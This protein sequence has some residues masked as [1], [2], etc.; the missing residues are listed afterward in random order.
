MLTTFTVQNF[1][2]LRDVTLQLTPLHAIVG[3]NDSGKSTLLA[4][5]EFLQE[6]DKSSGLSWDPRLSETASAFLQATD[7]G[8]VTARVRTSGR[9]QGWSEAWRSGGGPSALVVR[10][11]ADALRKPAN[12]IPE[13]KKIQF[14]LGRGLGLPGVYD[15]ILSRGDDAFHQIS[16]RLSKLFQS[17]KRLRLRAVSA[18]HKQIEI[19]LKN[20]QKISA[21][22]M[23]E[24]MLYYLAFE[25]LRHIEGV[26]LLLIE[27][28]ENGLHPARIAEV[29][30]MLRELTEQGTQ[31][32]LTTHS[33]LVLNE[34]K[35]EEVSVL[36]REEDGSRA[37]RL[38]DTPNFKARSEVFSLGELWLN[39]CNGIDEAPLLKGQEQADGSGASLL[40]A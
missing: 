38:C 21:E 15:A 40:P 20:G 14:V 37:M 2:C 19:E 32:L 8:R 27:E 34:L 24:G 11:E 12:L 5:I 13:N 17:V 18:T 39:Y 29:M 30:R 25:A 16:A 23:S 6:Y 22:H 26:G 1:G 31:V 3:P 33:P 28:P 10:W 4:A 36:W 35:P 7:K 9:G